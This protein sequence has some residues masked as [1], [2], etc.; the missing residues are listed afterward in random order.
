[1]RDKMSPWLPAIF[2]A[3]LSLITVVANVAGQFAGSTRDV[4]AIAFYGFMPMCFFFVGACL[5][6]LK[7]E[8]QELQKQIEELSKPSDDAAA[9]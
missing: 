5:S 7:K 3:T 2:C 9:S 8:R 4:G 1:M 6:Q